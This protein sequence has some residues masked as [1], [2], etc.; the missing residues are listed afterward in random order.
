MKQIP[1]EKNTSPTQTQW[2]FSKN[3]LWERNEMGVEVLFDSCKL[4]TVGLTI[5]FLMKYFDIL[6]NLLSWR[7]LNEKIDTT[8]LRDSGIDWTLSKSMDNLISQ[9]A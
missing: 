8:L 2:I 9:N 6:G 1:G 7:E 3:N 4:L 5:F